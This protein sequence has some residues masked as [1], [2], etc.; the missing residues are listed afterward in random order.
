M[1]D[2]RQSKLLVIH[3]N[4]EDKENVKSTSA[5]LCETTE[6]YEIRKCFCY[7]CQLYWFIVSISLFL[8]S[9]NKHE[10]RYVFPVLAVERHY[11]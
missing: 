6:N 8:M 5:H 1:W 11:N 4:Y 2:F 9:L 7:K 3:S 10:V